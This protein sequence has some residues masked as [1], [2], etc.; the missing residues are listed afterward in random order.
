MPPWCVWASQGH[1]GLSSPVLA[2]YAPTQGKCPDPEGKAP[3]LAS[4]PWAGPAGLTQSSTWRLPCQPK[5]ANHVLSREPGVTLPSGP[6]KPAPHSPCLLTLSLS[7]SPVWPCRART[8]LLPRAVSIRDQTR[9]S[10]S[11]VQRCVLCV[12]AISCYLGW[13]SLPPH[14][15]DRRP[16][17]YPS[18]SKKVFLRIAWNIHTKMLSKSQ[19]TS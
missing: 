14:W 16:S 7:E 15:G 5:Q 11:S 1:E 13:R 17:E 12:W 8:V 9:P 3:H 6:Y 18:P 4:S 10:L 19:G 2:R